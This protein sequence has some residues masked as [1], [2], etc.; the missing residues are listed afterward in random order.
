MLTMLARKPKRTLWFMMSSM[1]GPGAAL[2][3]KVAVTNSHHVLGF[4]GTFLVE[5]KQILCT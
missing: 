4:M 3:R 1:F 2:M 5:I